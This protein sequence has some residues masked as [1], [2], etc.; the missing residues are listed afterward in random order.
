[1]GQFQD[2]HNFYVVMD[3]VDTDWLARAA[4]KFHSAK[5]PPLAF[6]CP[7]TGH[8]HNFPV[9]PG[10][11][12][13]AWAWTVDA[14]VPRCAAVSATLAA[15][16]PPGYPPV[17]AARDIF[18]C[19]AMGLRHLHALGV[20]HGDVKLENV[21]VAP[22]PAA[23]ARPGRPAGRVAG[24]L[25]DFGHARHAAAAAADTHRLS[26]YG[27][28]DLTAPELLGNLALRR[29]A[30]ATASVDSDTPAQK[31]VRADAFKLDVYALGLVLYALLH[32]PARQP[33]AQ[34]AAVAAAPLLPAHLA[35]AEPRVLLRRLLAGR[36]GPSSSS[37]L[38]SLP[39]PP[40]PRAWDLPSL[41]EKDLA[42]HIL[43]DPALVDLLRRMLCVD[44][45]R[46]IDIFAVLAHPW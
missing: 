19:V 20:H 36:R 8:R 14:S 42:P 25:C 27:T 6:T 23:A 12:S 39:D 9:S 30:A 2:T 41:V 45:D 28:R 17:A 37:A 10:G 4:T 5:S 16:A 11:R 29:A 26:S 21:L 40:H 38:A 18:A 13:D 44:P 43:A 31:P 32:G 35:T 33:S 24:R 1:Y 3:L 22:E 46:R 34:R 15:T 7:R